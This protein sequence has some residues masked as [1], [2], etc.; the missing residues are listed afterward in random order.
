MKTFN[1]Y[2]SESVDKKEVS[3]EFIK[4]LLLNTYDKLA[5]E[6]LNRFLKKEGEKMIQLSERESNLLNLIKTYG[7]ISPDQFGNKN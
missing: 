7:K 4:G 2:I 3:R 5:K 6:I 1:Q